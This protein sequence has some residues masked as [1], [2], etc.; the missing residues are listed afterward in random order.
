MFTM[1]RTSKVRICFVFLT[2]SNRRLSLLTPYT[3]YLLFCKTS[4]LSSSSVFSDLSRPTSLSVPDSLQIKYEDYKDCNWR[5]Q[6]HYPFLKINIV[7][8]SKGRH[9][10]EMKYCWRTG[11]WKQDHPGNRFC[12]ARAVIGQENCGHFCNQ[13]DT[14]L[15]PIVTP[16]QLCFPA[17]DAAL[18]LNSYWLLVVFP[19][20]LIGHCDLLQFFCRNCFLNTQWKRASVWTPYKQVIV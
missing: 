18:S 14:K 9:R 11:H 2:F 6:S 5:L 15:E 3:K 19:L 17:L 10:K 7:K 4:N 1:I 20:I 13:S 12:L 8:C 16:C